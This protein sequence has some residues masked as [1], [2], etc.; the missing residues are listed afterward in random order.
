[1]AIAKRLKIAKTIDKYVGE[2][3]SG[4]S[5]GETLLL[6][7]V[8]RAIHPISKRAFSQWA[9]ETSIRRFFPSL[10]LDSMSSQHF[11]IQMDQVPE[12]ALE[13]IEKDLVDNIVKELN[14]NLDTLLYDAT[15]FF[16]FISSTNDKA[17]IAKR[18][19]NKQ[20]RYDLRQ[21][22]V[23]ILLSRDG[24]IPLLS[25]SYKGNQID[26]KQFP[27][28]LSKIRKRL[29]AITKSVSGVTLVYDKGNN[30]RDNQVVMDEANVGYITSLIPSHYRE[31]LEISVRKY[32]TISEGYLKG[33]KAYRS[34][35]R[36]WGA[37]RTIVIFRSEKLREGQVRGLEQNLEKCLGQLQEW[38]SNLAKP[39]S[40]PRKEGSAERKIN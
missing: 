1:M 26:V 10:D 24:K 31:L 35:K 13:A 28:S 5:V 20:K 27:D 39:R 11:W 19:H 8:N 2:G 4:I 22:N 32:K 17:E 36:I 15:N 21:F 37:D 34:S 29:E 23:A 16:T 9:N 3:R 18:G 25:T 30:S 33:T 38:K 6:A 12:S 40:G 14:L 7:A